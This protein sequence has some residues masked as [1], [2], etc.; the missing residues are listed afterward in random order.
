MKQQTTETKKPHTA[1]SESKAEAAADKSAAN[2]VSR[3]TKV[4]YRETYR[5]FRESG[6]G[7]ADSAYNALFLKAQS[8]IEEYNKSK[9]D[10]TTLYEHPKGWF[11]EGFEELEDISGRSFWHTVLGV[12][13]FL[14]KAARALHAIPGGIRK[15]FS[16]I[17]ERSDSALK[18]GRTMVHSLRKGGGVVLALLFV[19][20]AALYIGNTVS[21]AACIELFIDGKSVG[22]VKNA[23]TYNVSLS[24]AEAALSES[25]GVNYRIPSDTATYRVV[26]AVK[27]TY[28]SDSDITSA[29]LKSSEK[30]ITQGYGLYIDDTLAAVSDSRMITDKLLSDT[31][32]LYTRLYSSIKKN[33]ESI[34]FSNK[35]TIKEITVPKTMLKSEEQI[36]E[37]LGIDA[38]ENLNTL[39]LV[40]DST[41]MSTLEV[42]KL[43]PAL[44]NETVTTYIPEENLYYVTEILEKDVTDAE[45]TTESGEKAEDEE[46]D[47]DGNGIPDSE[48]PKTRVVLTFQR[49]EKQ[50]VS[51]IIPCDVK[52]VYDDTIREGRKIISVPG[53]D[54]IRESVYE[55]YYIDTEEIGR[56]L[57]EFNVVREPVTKTIRIGTK[58]VSEEERAAGAT[59]TFIKPYNG[60]ISSTFAGRVLFGAY[61][62]HGALDICGPAGAPIVASDGGK[63]VF[64]GWNDSYGNYVIVDHGDGIST[65]YAHMSAICCAVGEYVGQGWKIGEMG[66]TGRATGNHVHFEVRINGVRQ[67]PQ[68]YLS[69]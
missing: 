20:G 47:S 64:A 46:P 68:E 3:E 21:R 51:E 54:G 38:L 26:S 18:R 34:S 52:Y 56:K 39:L 59:G 49:T 7:V 22:Y 35:I 29:L 61:E 58:K 55:V 17:T 50:T 9:E 12:L 48:E 41:S 19:A 6:L 63:V 10:I 14:P 62:F 44:D 25:L 16:G 67:D 40:D 4:R 42:A 43:L 60:Q 13:L 5:R 28:L 24:N 23:D 30:Y 32:D 1:T 2:N 31:L 65:L 57:L 11:A 27:P 69:N 33:E 37:I 53:V 45:N 8:K 66:M 15:G 36:R